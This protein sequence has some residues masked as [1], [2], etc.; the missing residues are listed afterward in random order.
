MGTGDAATNGG[1]N[2]IDVLTRGK[3]HDGVRAEMDGGMQFIQ[4][5]FHVAGDGRVADVGVDLAF[6]GQTDPHRFQLPLE[7]NLICRNH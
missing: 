3:V 7:M 1:A 5:F 2:P 6:G 4:F